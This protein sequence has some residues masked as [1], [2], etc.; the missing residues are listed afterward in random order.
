MESCLGDSGLF[1]L[2]FSLRLVQLG[3]ILEET[4][5][6]R[7]VPCWATSLGSC[8]LGVTHDHRTFL[9]PHMC[10][11]VGLGQSTVELG[12]KTEGLGGSL[13]CLFLDEC[14]VSDQSQSLYP[15]AEN[16]RLL[17]NKNE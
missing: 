9:G 16:H 5:T 1:L 6:L 4:G 2:F 12:A 15:E 8:K 7:K 17:R 11:N 14:K 13:L 10:G 3:P